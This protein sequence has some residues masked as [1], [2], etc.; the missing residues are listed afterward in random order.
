M[1]LRRQTEIAGNCNREDRKRAGIKLSEQSRERLAK[2]VQT[3]IR[4]TFIG[5]IANIEES[6][7]RDLWGHGL[8]QDECTKE[9]LKWRKVWEAART[10]ILNNGNN[11]LRA[12]MNELM[13]YD[14]TWKRHSV[15]MKVEGGESYERQ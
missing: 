9:Q 4:T 8:D 10:E 15:N 1:D 12:A 7:G 13:N 2:I 5:A 6:I 14:V 11:Q 3:K